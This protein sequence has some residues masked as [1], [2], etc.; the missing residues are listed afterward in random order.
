[1]SL[2]K[3]LRLALGFVV[4][5]TLLAGGISWYSVSH[6]GEDLSRAV[7]DASQSTEVLNSLR[8]R[9]QELST[10]SD[11]SHIAL[12][13]QHLEKNGVKSQT[14][15]SSCHA[16][17]LAT[18]S[19]ETVRGASKSLREQVERASSLLGGN[20]D[21]KA[22][23]A[24]RQFVERWQPAF[25]EY[26]QKATAGNYEAAHEV[27]VNKLKPLEVEF[28]GA[29]REFSERRQAGLQQASLEARQ[30]A[31]RANLVQVAVVCVTV[32]LVGML[33]FL[34]RGARSTLTDVIRRLGQESRRVAAA[35]TQLS[36]SSRSLA[37][38]AS[39]QAASLEQTSA[40]TEEIN[41]TAQQ[42]AGHAQTA[43]QQLA[44]VAETLA[45][46]EQAL[47]AMQRAMVDIN[48]SNQKV[49]KI[50]QVI[51]D[52]AFQTNILALNAAVEAARAGEAGLGFAVVADE[53][54]NLA[55][56]SA[57]AAQETAELI[58]DSIA[59][60]KDGG[61]AF[62]QVAAAV[63]AVTEASRQTQQ[64]M[65]VL[66]EGALNQAKGTE[67]ILNAV[68]EI[69]KVTERTAAGADEAAAL[70]HELEERAHTLDRL[71]NQ[72]SSL[73]GSSARGAAAEAEDRRA[74]RGSSAVEEV[75]RRRG[76]LASSLARAKSTPSTFSSGSKAATHQAG[77]QDDFW[78]PV[79][80]S[81]QHR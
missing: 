34:I 32:A 70:G 29:L 18:E 73:V 69:Q 63:Q 21:T 16:P 15:C 44:R 52:I 5:T 68:L 31:R 36:S 76:E 13:V 1:M 7:A 80:R 66:R 12:A 65:E 58:G 47:Q 23:A 11:Y 77:V 60:A 81:V 30:Q 3:K 38:G 43:S 20:E 48:E 45:K 27:L 26:I 59:K 35:A 41:T 56:R 39:E 79:T 10:A 72:L 8:A 2:E 50:I 62:D 71:V 64:L 4:L 42:N 9:V 49:S 14:S 53:V 40:S 54:R 55:Q 74:V 37:Q 61:A 19:L 51:D 17:E 78:K 6:L 67:Q 75:P 25:E 24:F 46:A 28:D 33:A 57:Q 22:L